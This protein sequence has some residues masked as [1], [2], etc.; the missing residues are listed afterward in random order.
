MRAIATQS[1]SIF[2][3]AH[4]A[5]E[6]LSRY[7]LAGLYLK[8]FLG[9]IHLQSSALSYVN[10]GHS[11]LALR[12]NQGLYEFVES[13]IDLA[14]GID[15][16]YLFKEQHISF[17]KQDELMLISQTVMDQPGM[18]EESVLGL[19]NR[20]NI[21][22]IQHLKS[23]LNQKESDRQTDLV[24][25]HLKV[26]E[27]LMGIGTQLKVHFRNDIS[28][29]AKLKDVVTLFGQANDISQ[30]IQLNMNLA[31]EECITNTIFYGYQDHDSHLIYVGF[32]VKDQQLMVIIEDDGVAFDP[33]NDA[34]SHDDSASLDD[35]VIGGLGIKF[36]TNIM[37]DVSYRREDHKNIL[38]LMIRLNKEESEL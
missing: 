31:L 33:L 14:F 23:E 38:S 22:V 32:E 8:C 1:D 21:S 18:S 7:A 28:E 4:L 37:D 3:M 36:V 16:N 10:A 2:D 29:L 26:K 5:N 13:D 27:R 35:M 9:R 24:L 20:K 17:D 6:Q 34:P 30:D 19:M 25:L 11:K 12:L 15:S